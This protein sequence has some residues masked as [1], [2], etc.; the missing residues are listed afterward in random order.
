MFS[1][2]GISNLLENGHRIESVAEV[3]AHSNINTTKSYLVR[4][5]KIENNPLLSLNL[6]D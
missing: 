6:R 5:E 2:G 1:Q 3:L 4:K